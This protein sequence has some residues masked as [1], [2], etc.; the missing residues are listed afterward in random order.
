MDS[1]QFQLARSFISRRRWKDFNG[2]PVLR[3]WTVF[4]FVYGRFSAVFCF[5]FFL[6]R[7]VCCLRW[8]EF[9]NT[10]SKFKIYSFFLLESIVL[11]RSEILIHFDFWNFSIAARSKKY[12]FFLKV[13][14]LDEDRKC[15]GDSDSISV[16]GF[17]FKAKK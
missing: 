15:D 2:F 5:F 1:I 11:S 6:D 4:E 8:I 3:L 17:W 14:K 9:E 13:W 7:L 12:R 16:S 10:F